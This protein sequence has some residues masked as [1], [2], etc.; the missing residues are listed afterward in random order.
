VINQPVIR[1]R[2]N[3]TPAQTAAT[4]VWQKFLNIKVDGIFGPN[5]ESATKAYQKAHGL[6]SDGVVGEKSWATVPTPVGSA[7]LS[8]APPKPPTPLQQQVAASNAAVTAANVIA[9]RPSQVPVKRPP[10]APPPAAA[11]QAAAQAA[12]AIAAGKKPPAATGKN[13]LRD[14]AA[15]ASQ[16][17]DQ[18][19]TSAAE[20]IRQVSASVQKQ[21]MWLRILSGSALVLGGIVSVKVLMPESKRARARY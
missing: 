1:V 5:T 17:I 13:P 11:A 2:S 10:T 15:R 9:A 6:T 20:R 14:V 18:T 7:P 8:S 19:A 4:K 12:S 16:V 3:A 21:P